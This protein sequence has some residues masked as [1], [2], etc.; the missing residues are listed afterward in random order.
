MQGSDFFHLK[1]IFP[2]NR[3]NVI[4]LVFVKNS[5]KNHNT[6]SIHSTGLGEL[7]FFSSGFH[8]SFELINLMS[9]NPRKKGKKRKSEQTF[10]VDPIQPEVIDFHLIS[11]NF[12][13]EIQQNKKQETRRC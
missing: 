5:S 2:F 1:I 11:G 13:C 12:H 9:K 7:G 10:S 8:F 4:Q 6:F 3:H